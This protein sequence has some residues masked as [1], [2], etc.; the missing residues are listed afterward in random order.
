MK[1]KRAYGIRARA[2][3]RRR[4][5]GRP[6]YSFTAPRVVTPAS[7]VVSGYTR[8]AG[9]YGRFNRSRLQGL[10]EEKKFFDGELTTTAVPSAGTILT[11]SM[12]LITAGAGE[13]QR[14]G[15]KCK[16]TSLHLKGR[17]I[18][19]QTTQ[20]TVSNIT[21][22]IVYL[23]KQCN[24]AAATVGDILD[25]GQTDDYLAFRNLQ[26]TQRFR[27]L[28]DKTYTQN[29]TAGGG[30]G[31]ASQYPETVRYFKLNINCNE[32]LEFDGSTGAITDLTSNNFG[33]L[34]IAETNNTSTI[35]Y[36]YRLR[37]YG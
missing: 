19:Q 11:P 4:V 28:H 3:T 20:N 24:G 18:L 2:R 5:G 1:R 37:F 12:N 6:G 33:I 23:D 34:A 35:A 36:Q 13:S 32:Q 21:R 29:Y 26:N 9:Y 22:I 15:R 25:L 7:L 31:T 27:I 30:N 8:S 14:I 17:L 16:I 10:P